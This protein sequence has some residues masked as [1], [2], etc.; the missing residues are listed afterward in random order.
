MNHVRTC[1]RSRLGPVAYALVNSIATFQIGRE[2]DA[3][4]EKAGE[5]GKGEERED[6]FGEVDHFK[7]DC[8]E[9][10]QRTRAD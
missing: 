8:G 1:G 4:S 7:G 2:V 5:R 9:D 6:P 10:A 3:E